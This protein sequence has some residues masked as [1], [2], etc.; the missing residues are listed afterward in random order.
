MKVV[1]E[2]QKVNGERKNEKRKR[3]RKETGDR[4]RAKVIREGYRFSLL[5]WRMYC[6]R[7]DF[8]SFRLQA[9]QT[10]MVRFHHPALTRIGNLTLATRKVSRLLRK[11]PFSFFCQYKPCEHS[12]R[13]LACVVPANLFFFFISFVQKK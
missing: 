13:Y 6:P 12:A 5:A 10:S 11:K 1:Y 2:E 4:E 8:F 9:T 3:E 7:R